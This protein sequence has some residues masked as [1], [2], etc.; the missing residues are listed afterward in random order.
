[1]KDNMRAMLLA[2]P[3]LLMLSLGAA[4]RGDSYRREVEDWRAKHQSA[5][6]RD[7]GWLT[8]VG[9]DWLKEGDNRVGA[10]PA[11]EVPLPPGSAP[12][13]VAT[14]SLHAGKAVLHPAP[15]VPLTLNGKP[16]SETTLR[17]DDDILSINQLKFYLILRGDRGRHSSQGQ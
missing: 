2:I 11:S 4:D 15:G 9:L 12:S 16:A 1:M 8:V 5:L 17:E 7:Y 3:A 13:R 14:I 10:D 6:A